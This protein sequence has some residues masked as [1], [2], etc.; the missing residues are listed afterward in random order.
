[1]CA[2]HACRPCRPLSLSVYPSVPAAYKHGSGIPPLPS[3]KA[4]ALWR[5]AAIVVSDKASLAVE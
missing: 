4:S 1:M 5:A 2:E 3:V